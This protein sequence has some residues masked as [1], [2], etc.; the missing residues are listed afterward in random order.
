MNKIKVINGKQ[1]SIQVISSSEKQ[2]HISRRDAEMDARA[3]KAVKT[4]VEK[5][6]FCKKPIAK[7]DTVT[8]SAYVEYANGE[9]KYVN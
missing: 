4:A 6:K 2:N 7:Y 1:H 8:K 5:A 9:K 3:T